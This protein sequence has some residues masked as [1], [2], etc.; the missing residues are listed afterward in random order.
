MTCF[1]FPVTCFLFPVTCDLFPV[2]C[3]LFPVT[4]FL[5]LSYISD[6]S[7][8]ALAG[9]LLPCCLSESVICVIL[10]LLPNPLLTTIASDPVLPAL[11]FA[12]SD[13]ASA[14]PFCT[15]PI[16]AVGEV[17]PLPEDTTW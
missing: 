14:C 8:P 15:T 16:S 17:E 10:C 5:F 2:S 12:T 4:C 3:D 6:L 1:L 11:T 13:Y 7:L 9:S